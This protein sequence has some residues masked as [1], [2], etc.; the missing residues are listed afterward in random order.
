MGAHHRHRAPDG[1]SRKRARPARGIDEFRASVWRERDSAPAITADQL[2]TKGRQSAEK[3]RPE[4][5]AFDIGL[6]APRH[7][8]CHVHT[9]QTDFSAFSAFCLPFVR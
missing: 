4:F 3:L 9:P 8:E 5:A 2:P 6:L 7:L 1:W